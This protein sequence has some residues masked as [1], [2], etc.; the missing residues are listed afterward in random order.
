MLAL[1][2]LGFLIVLFAALVARQGAL[3]TFVAGRYTS[4]YNAV[5]MGMCKDG[6]ELEQDFELDEISETDAW[7][8]S[9]IDGI[10]RGGNSFVQFTC[11]EY[12]AGALGAFWPLGTLGTLV[13]P[14][15][16]PIGV[17]ASTLA[18]ALVLTAV[19][20]T[21]AAGATGLG[22]T[23]TAS[24]ALL[25]KNFNGKL[26]LN[27]KLRE[28]PVRQRLYPYLNTTPYVFFTMT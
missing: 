3:G 25:A 23:F 16:M 21:P 18:K 2:F 6:F 9:V 22:V 8:G 17:L 20:G 11:E 14:T 5:A 15:T 28:V 24:N 13:T 26:L 1:T 7:G 27:S 10:F 12:A 19:T 4:T